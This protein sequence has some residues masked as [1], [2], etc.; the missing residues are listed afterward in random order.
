M[1]D[2]IE[3][4]GL[5]VRGNHGVFGHER[6]DGQ[7][8]VVDITVWMD[9]APAAASDALAEERRLPQARMMARLRGNLPLVALETVEQA[10]EAEASDRLAAPLL[11]GL[12]RRWFVGTGPEA[13]ARLA[14]FAAQ[15]GVDEVMVSP[16]AAAYDDDP[17]DATPARV[18]TLELLVG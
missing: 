11:D 4:R 8:F 13:R 16:V 2:R 7:E 9:L 6:T 17:T 14:A 10:A 1:T 5:T 3:L 15:H 18:E 12:R